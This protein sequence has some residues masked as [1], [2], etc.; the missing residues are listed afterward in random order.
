LIGLNNNGSSD[1]S[2]SNRVFRTI[3]LIAILIALLTLVAQLYI[4]YLQY[5]EWQAEA[6]ARH[7]ERIA[8]AW[9]IVTT[10]SPGNSGKVEALEF[11]ARNKVPLT[12]I[13]LSCES[14]GGK[15]DSTRR[16]CVSGRVYLRGLDLGQESIGHRVDLSGSDFSGADLTGSIFDGA[17]LD[18]SNF[19]GAILRDS[20]FKD[21]FLSRA[22]F[23]GMIILRHGGSPFPMYDENEDLID[24]HELVQGADFR[25]SWLLGASFLQ[26]DLFKSKFAGYLDGV[27]F[28]KARVTQVDFS[29]AEL[30]FMTPKE[31]FGDAWVWKFSSDFD[32]PKFNLKLQVTPKALINFC[33]IEAYVDYIGFEADYPGDYLCQK[34]SE[35]TG[36][37]R[38]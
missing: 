32:L 38:E 11:L 31:V 14:H 26:A 23:D 15:W 6:V 16:L 7:E 25:G 36:N 37:L 22:T 12:N 27:N 1:H 5:G 29:N 33:N 19:A 8:R 28:S 9:Q 4:S 10:R 30:S 2:G 24:D 13:D 20:S 3:E 18:D 17:K 35:T 34:W 21:A